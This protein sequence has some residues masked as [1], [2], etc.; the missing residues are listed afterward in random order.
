MKK[1]IVLFSVIFL[2][3]IIY[4]VNA[5]NLIDYMSIGDSL[6]LGI[7]S[8]GNNTYSYHDYLKNYLDNNNLLNKTYFYYSKNNYKI[9]EL[10]N[11]INNNKKIV[12]KDK[13]YNIKKDLRE[14]DLITIAI[15]M[16]ELI[17]IIEYNGTLNNKNEVY[18][19]VDKLI[20]NMDKLVNYIKK[21]SSSNIIII[22]YY[23]PY[24]TNNLE[25][26]R[27]FSYINDKYNTIAKKYKVTYID[28]YEVIKSSKEYLPNYKDYHLNSKGYLKIA[29]KIIEKLDY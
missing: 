18:L 1:L 7:N 10:L 24:Q 16:D 22:G 29:S 9:E 3:F 27:L 2:T 4:K 12:F 23:N 13:T 8:Y 14:A 5:N 21:M 19:K 26:N 25:I 11:D 15:G 28:I 20:S 6:D 17:S